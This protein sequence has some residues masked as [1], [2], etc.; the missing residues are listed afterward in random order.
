MKIPVP[1]IVA[2]VEDGLRR[3]EPRNRMAV[4]AARTSLVGILQKA[5]PPTGNLQ[6]SDFRALK[7]LREDASIVIVP[8]DKGWSTVVMDKQEYKEKVRSLQSD[9][10]TYKQLPRNPAASLKCQMNKLLLSLNSTGSIPDH[11]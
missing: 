8:A 4:A 1:H 3:V 11:L 2:A 9:T 10:R 6:P 5:K 7:S